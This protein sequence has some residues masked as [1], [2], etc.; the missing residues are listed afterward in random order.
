[1][2]LI[3]LEN[4]SISFSDKPILNNVSATI[5]KKDKIALIGRNG[6]GKSTLMRILARAIECDKGELKTK[7]GI[8]VSYLEQI[9]KDNDKKIFDIIAEGLGKIG[10]IIS[11]YQNLIANEKLSEA[12]DLQEEIEKLN[13]WQYI[14]KIQEIIDRFALTDKVDFSTLSGGWKKR[15]MLARA[16]IKEPDVLLLDEPTNHMD[17]SAIIDLENILKKY[18]GALVLISHDRSFI[19]NLVNKVFD[20]DRGNLSVFNCNFVD[21][22]KRKDEQLNA[23]QLAETRFNKKLEQEEAWIRKSIKAR[24]TRNEGRVSALKEMRKLFVNRY[25]K[26]GNIKIHT[27]N[28]KEH[29]S[30]II[31]EVKNIDYKINETHLIKDFSLIVLK[32]E[33]IGII[34]SNGTG[35]STLIKLLIDE[36]KADNGSINRSKTINLA[37]FQQMSKDVNS[38]VKAVDFIA[39]GKEYVEINGKN[40]NVIGY[41]RQFL[42]TSKQAVSPIKMLSGGE[43]NKLMLAK[44]LSK[45][46]NLLVLDEPTNDLDVET[47]ELLEE[48]LISYTGTVIIV[49]HDRSFI[50]NIT[51]STIVMEANGVINQYAGGYNDYLIEKKDKKP[52]TKKAN[53]A[54]K[55]ANNKKLSYKQQQELNNILNNIKTTE[56][57]INEIQAKLNNPSSYKEQ[58]P[59]NYLI[60]LSTLKLELE[61]LYEKWSEL[62]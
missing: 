25:K 19:K 7:K 2:S 24:R 41:L 9:V 23:E 43:K 28:T 3:T 59:K 32:G 51:T 14:H 1:M 36:L 15:V 49:S 58:N 53:L 6:Q 34:G 60:K 16:I 40:K 11:K 29:M 18:N 17:I 56:D 33:K 46:A 21:Y 31:F 55:K 4:I 62:E 50:N 37:Y 13:G 35:K 30:K 12:G 44:I 20:L 8:K 26:Q 42:F 27:L 61:N 10:T 45:P 48:M 38:N 22:I 52:I 57:K 39:D 5:A 54:T 47:L